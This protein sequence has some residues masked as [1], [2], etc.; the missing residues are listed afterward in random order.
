MLI[1]SSMDVFSREKRSWIMSRIRSGDTKPEFVVRSMLHRLGLRFSLRRRKLPGSPD[2]VLAKHRTAVFVHGCFWHRHGCRT[3]TTPRTRKAFW[4]AKFARNVARDRENRR[5]LR[6][7]G[8]RTIV[9]WECQVMRDP[10]R[11]VK[12]IFQRIAGT[13]ASSVRS[14]K[15]SMAY[16]LPEKREILRAAEEK[17]HSYLDDRKRTR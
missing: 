4:N 3:A 10:E 14:K 6:K 8:W 2:I 16:P 1:Y 7:L 11:A 15:H 12:R 13:A 17:L 5:E 9:V